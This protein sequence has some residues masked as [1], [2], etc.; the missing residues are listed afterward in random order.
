MWGD[1]YRGLKSW[2]IKLALQWMS[3]KHDVQLES[4]WKL[5]KTRYRGEKVAQAL[6]DL[7]ILKEH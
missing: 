7:L 5:P 2:L 4:Q 3:E 1:G 6:P